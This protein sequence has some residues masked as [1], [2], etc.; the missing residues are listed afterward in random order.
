MK[1]IIQKKINQEFKGA[2]IIKQSLQA[3]LK[4]D[5]HPYKVL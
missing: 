4:E 5:I 3:L 2:E 1:E